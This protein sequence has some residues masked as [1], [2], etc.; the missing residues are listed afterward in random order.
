MVFAHNS[1]VGLNS[2][3]KSSFL[4][5]FSDRNIDNQSFASC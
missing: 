2:D 1:T 4:C 5:A 3:V